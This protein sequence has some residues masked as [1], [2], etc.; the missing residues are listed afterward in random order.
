MEDMKNSASAKTRLH[1]W[2]GEDPAELAAV[3]PN[4]NASQIKV[5]VFLAAAG[6]DVVAPIEHSRL[7]EQALKKA[8]VPVETLYYPN[9]GHGFYSPEH[10]AE[11]YTRL[12]D[13]LG[14]HI[15]NQR[16]APN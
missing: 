14:R 3:S 8:G 1:D 4:R 2:I 6:E 15:G 9:E 13:F 10:R 16:P 12:L 5:P 11:F 7:M